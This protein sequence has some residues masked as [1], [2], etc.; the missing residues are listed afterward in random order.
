ME[1]TQNMT[2]RLRLAPYTHAVPS[3]EELASEIRMLEQRIADEG[4]AWVSFER[5]ILDMQQR[6]AMLAEAMLP[7]AASA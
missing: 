5:E 7:S 2:L 3:S 6:R 1:D 4:S